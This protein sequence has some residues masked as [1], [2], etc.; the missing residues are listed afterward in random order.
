MLKIKDNVDLK[1][2][3]KFG[4]EIEQSYMYG[5]EEEDEK[6]PYLY[7]RYEIKNH[8]MN[9]NVSQIILSPSLSCSEINRTLKMGCVLSKFE[10]ESWRLFDDVLF[11]LI[12]AGLVEKV[13][14]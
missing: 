11:D 9:Y 3:E 1:E 7:A 10:Y 2:L 12:Q 13:E 6:L 14:E 4:F 8:I 5:E